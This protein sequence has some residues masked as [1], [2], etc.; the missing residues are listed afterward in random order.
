[1]TSVKLIRKTMRPQKPPL[2]RHAALTQAVNSPGLVVCRRSSRCF[3]IASIGAARLGNKKEGRLWA[4]LC[5]LI[6]HKRG[7]A[8]VAGK[9]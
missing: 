5:Y 1:M 4:A 9:G 6:N 3:S 2:N 8:V 7:C